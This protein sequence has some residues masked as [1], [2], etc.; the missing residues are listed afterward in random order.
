MIQ[1]LNSTELAEDQP[2]DLPFELNQTESGYHVEI[3]TP[4]I[5]SIDELQLEISDL[6]IKLKVIKTSQFVQIPFKT[7]INSDLAKA[8]LKK[9]LN[10]LI[11]D[12]TFLS[13]N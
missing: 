12:A 2:E 4:G 7:P 8:K 1:V 3:L 13:P 9:K 5:V 11:I 10:R 6:Q